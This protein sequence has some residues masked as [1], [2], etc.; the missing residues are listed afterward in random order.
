MSI[1]HV[2]L[3]EILLYLGSS[4]PVG[5]PDRLQEIQLHN[6]DTWGCK[7][8]RKTTQRAVLIEAKR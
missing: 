8:Q 7:K 1:C 6:H 2:K 3:P 4:P 5:P